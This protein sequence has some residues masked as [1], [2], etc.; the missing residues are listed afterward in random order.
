MTKRLE[1][2]HKS[3]KRDGKSPGNRQRD[4]EMGSSIQDMTQALGPKPR[5]GI[6]SLTQG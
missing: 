4:L 2:Y 3:Y 1:D 5:R 6:R